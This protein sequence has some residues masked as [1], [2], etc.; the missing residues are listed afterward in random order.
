[1]GGIKKTQGFG[2]LAAAFEKAGL[3]TG[4]RADRVDAEGQRADAA[5]SRDLPGAEGGYRGEIDRVNAW[6]SE[7]RSPAPGREEGV[8]AVAV[9]IE[10]APAT[11]EQLRQVEHA[12]GFALPPSF[13]SF[14]LEVGAVSLLNPWGDATTPVGQLVAASASLEADVALTA[15]RF[16]HAAE[17]S[18]IRLD[19]TAPRLLLH[20]CEEQGGEAVFAL[21][22]SRDDRGDSPVFMRFHDEPDALY[23]PSSDFR[24]WF[25]ERLERLRAEL[26]EDARRR[27][28]R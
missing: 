11:P 26:Q 13:A 28:A 18:G 10:G 16:V 24:Q 3:A 20:V 7:L 2:S 27:G 12:L 9:R 21:C 25:R 6:F 1:M 5:V 23:H 15:A 14:L 4:A 22:A 8:P 17:E 19:P